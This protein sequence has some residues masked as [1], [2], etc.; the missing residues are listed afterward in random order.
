MKKTLLLMLLSF[1][2]FSG[3]CK[4]TDEAVESDIEHPTKEEWLEVYITH[5]IKQWADPW[6]R[7]IAVTVW[8]V[9][10][11]QEIAITLTSANGQEEISTSAKNTYIHDVE[12]IVKAIL[13]NYNWAKI[14]KVT[15]QYI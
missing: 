7:R 11:E 4:H 3:C 14:Y 13:E 1:I 2:L 5:R 15:V 10:Q 6:Q 9:P 12:E 8:I